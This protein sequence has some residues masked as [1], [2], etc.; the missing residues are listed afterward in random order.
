MAALIISNFASF[1]SM[2]NQTTARLNSLNTTIARLKDAI[3]TA[4]SGYEG[5]PGTQ[6]ETPMA[7]AN[8]A[9][10]NNFGVQAEPDIPGKAGTDY[11]Y[12]MNNLA[13]AWENFWITASPYIDQL[14]NGTGGM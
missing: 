6:F 3:A 9:G 13:V 5:I 11:A 8:M 1:G 4:S 12:A 7:G 10:G 2:T 14:D